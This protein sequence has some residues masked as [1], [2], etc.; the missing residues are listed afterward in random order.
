[1]KLE[2]DA[3][4]AFPREV[5]YSTYRDRLPALVPYLP[6]IKGITVQKREDQGAVSKLVN[7]WEAKGEVPKVAQSVIKPEMLAWLDHATWDQ[8]AWTVD[9][10]I[11]TRMFTENVKCFGH[12]TYEADGSGCLLKIRGELNVDLKGI[13][14]VPRLLAGTVAPHVEKFVIALLTPNLLSVAK[15]LDAF[16]QAEQK[17]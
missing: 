8:D 9:W 12:N 17:G 14:G 5:V 4:I 6:N 13:P 3:R 16:L 10:R 15:G 11:E 2:A 7:L 1:M